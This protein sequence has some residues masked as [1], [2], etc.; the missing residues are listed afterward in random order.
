[1]MQEPGLAHR[2]CVRDLAQGSTPLATLGKDFH[3]RIDDAGALSW[4]LGVLALS[5]TAHGSHPRTRNAQNL[6]VIRFFRYGDLGHAAPACNHA[7]HHRHHKENAMAS[8]YPDGFTWGVSTAAYQIEGAVTEDGR[9]PS[10]WDTFC[11]QPGKIADG[12]DGS[13]ACDH[14]HRYPQDVALM[15]DLGVDAYRFSIAW[16]RVMPNG[17]GQVN[18]VGL[19]FYDR[20][21]SPPCRPC[22]IGTPRR[23]SR[24]AMAG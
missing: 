16:P 5:P 11:K 9:G 17:T 19:D 20:Q 18:A 22:S 8:N 3:R 14:Y 12:S 15:K 1:M 10:V 23:R 7:A 4:S 13:I 2:D 24:T 21:A 6:V